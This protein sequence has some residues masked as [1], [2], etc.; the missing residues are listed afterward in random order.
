MTHPQPKSSPA[1]TPPSAGWFIVVLV[2]AVFGMILY[3]R[4]V[5]PPG[6]GVQEKLPALDVVPLTGQGEPAT[7]ADLRGKVVL[8]NFF[9]TWC[10]PCR[11][12]LPHLAELRRQM[13]KEK[14]G[15]EFVLLPIAC[16]ELDMASLRAETQ[17]LLSRLDLDLPTYADPSRTTRNAFDSVS[18]F[19][20]FPTSFIL[21]REGHI[22]KVWIGYR[23]DTIEEMETTAQ[24][25]L[26]E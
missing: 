11:A 21:D 6:L 26:R 10:G 23:P 22:Q 19:D 5:V 16:D 7:L 3:A 12:E 18:R 25:M 13:A 20:S 15:N 1:K 17:A 9:A 24:R 8:V 2:V 14:S 4:H